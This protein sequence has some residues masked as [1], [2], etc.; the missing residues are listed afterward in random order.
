MEYDPSGESPIRQQL[1]NIIDQQ[2]TPKVK[3]PLNT[4]NLFYLERQPKLKAEHPLLNGNDISRLVANEWKEMTSEQKKPYK[5]KATELYNKF[6]LENPN[7]HYEKASDKKVCKKKKLRDE[8]ALLDPFGALNPNN[9]S[10]QFISSALLLAQF[11]L[12]RKD[13]QNDIIRAIHQGRFYFEPNT[14]NILQPIPTPAI[15]PN[16]YEQIPHEDPIV[17]DLE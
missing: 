13:V 10:T 12:T 5:E 17:T 14:P 4:Y 8:N 9:P 16:N 6:K 2:N 7:Y 3:R 11:V 1:Q 15:A